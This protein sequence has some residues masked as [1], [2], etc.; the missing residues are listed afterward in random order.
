MALNS[1]GL[2]GH[3]GAYSRVY[4]RVIVV[5]RYCRIVAVQSSHAE[6]QT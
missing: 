1:S 6:N 4:R 3:I 5:Q 2:H